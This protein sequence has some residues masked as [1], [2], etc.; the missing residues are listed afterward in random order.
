MRVLLAIIFMIPTISAQTLGGF[1]T[2]LQEANAN[3]WNLFDFSTK[4]TNSP[5][6]DFPADAGDDKEIYST[7]SGDQGFSLFASN[8]SSNQFFV[9]D[10]TTAGIERVEF[11]AYVEDP[12]S[13]RDLEIYI[14]S[15]NNFYYSSPFAVEAAGWSS[16]GYSF[17]RDQWFVFN[18]TNNQFIPV[19]LDDLILS[20]ISEIGVNFHPSSASANGK[21][22]ALDNFGLFPEYTNP[23]LNINTTEAGTFISFIAEAGIQYT[24]EATDDLSKSNWSTFASPIN[25]EG[26]FLAAVP[27]SPERFFRV[28]ATPFIVQNP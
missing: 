12:S 4:E 11:E 2:F 15:G 10:Y 25:A 8:I 6:W 28:V 1:E 13:F 27:A 17:K 26:P 3:T 19:V 20:N 24:I 7:F 21:V 16:V 22:A 5:L 18:E 23:K 14:R 9:G